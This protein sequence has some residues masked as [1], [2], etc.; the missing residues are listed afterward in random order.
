MSFSTRT[1]SA[2]IHTRHE[3]YT[4]TQTE[5]SL[6]IRGKKKKKITLKKTSLNEYKVNTL[7]NGN[8]P[9]QKS[10]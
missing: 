5:T 8:V 1:H 9:A 10:N 7:K 6:D 2:Y 4:R 3:T